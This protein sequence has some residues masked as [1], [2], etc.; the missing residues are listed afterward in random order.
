MYT[1]LKARV[2]ND[3][4]WEYFN[5]EK[6]IKKGGPLSSLIFIA[7]F[8]GVFRKVQWE[9]KGVDV[10]GEFLNHLRFADDVVV[11]AKK[12]D[13]LKNILEELNSAKR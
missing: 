10:N 5:I 2:V 11:T 7:A 9:G 4:A 13:E 1:G 8:E 6:G 12:K 3:K